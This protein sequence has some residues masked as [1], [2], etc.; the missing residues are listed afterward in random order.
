MKDKL[1]R[2]IAALLIGG[3][4]A[5]Y[6]PP[7][8]RIIFLAFFLLLLFRLWFWWQPKDFVGRLSRPEILLL[9]CSLSGWL[10]LW[11]K[12]GKVPGR[13][14]GYRRSTNR[15]EAEG[16]GTRRKQRPG[17]FTGPEGCSEKKE[18]PE[19]QEKLQEAAGTTRSA[20]NSKNREKQEEGQELPG[21]SGG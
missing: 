1:S 17:S 11:L 12:C 19:Q 6:S 5:V 20:W 8:V 4:S 15:G 7:E 18:T 14:S 16:L 2:F 3:F 10:C 21:R 13:S 9:A